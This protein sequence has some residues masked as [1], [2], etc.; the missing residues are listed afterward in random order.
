MKVL[1]RAKL[2]D[3]YKLNIHYS[4]KDLIFLIDDIENEEIKLYKLKTTFE[5]LKKKN[6]DFYLFQTTQKFI[7]IVNIC[8]ESNN[9]SIE[10]K[11]NNILI[12]E[13]KNDFFKNKSLQIEIPEFYI[14][15]DE[16]LENLKENILVY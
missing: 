4:D 9:C 7:E 16:E 3:K 12:L 5:N 1:K 13:I 2:N 10:L 14:K 11:K 8:I 6:E 15:F